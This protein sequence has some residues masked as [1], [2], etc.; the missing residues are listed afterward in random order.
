MYH[1]HICLANASWDTYSRHLYS[2]YK[3]GMILISSKWEQL[4][5]R[6]ETMKSFIPCQWNLVE[7][8]LVLC[9]SAMYIR[10]NLQG[11]NAYIISYLTSLIFNKHERAIYL[12]LLEFRAVFTFGKIT[13]WQ[14]PHSHWV[15]FSLG[16]LAAR[17][18]CFIVVYSSGELRF[19]Y[20]QMFV[21]F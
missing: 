10:E 20:I 6:T 21:V 17:S 12:I 5:S 3:A 15:C 9:T 19:L 13:V 7:K 18:V 1:V 8:V 4:K 16:L 14:H 11:Y 2:L